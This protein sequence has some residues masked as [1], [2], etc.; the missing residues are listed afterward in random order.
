MLWWSTPQTKNWGCIWFRNKWDVSVWRTRN[1]STEL[2]AKRR[3]AI[4]AHAHDSSILPASFYNPPKFAFPSVMLSWVPST[5][6]FRIKLSFLVCP[7][8]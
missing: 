1:G 3:A 8:L 5:E 7:V 2:P 4:P 6:N